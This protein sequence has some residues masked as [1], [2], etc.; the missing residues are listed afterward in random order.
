MKQKSLI[1]LIIVCSSIISCKKEI[2]SLSKN[3]KEEKTSIENVDTIKKKDITFDGKITQT[4]LELDLESRLEFKAK[5]LS[6]LNYIIKKI[7]IIETKRTRLI[8]GLER[9]YKSEKLKQQEIENLIFESHSAF[10]K[11]TLVINEDKN[12]YPRV[13]VEEHIFKDKKSAKEAFIF[14]NDLKKINSI[15]YNISKEPSSL[16]LE[17]NRLYFVISGGWYMM[18]I[19]KEVEKELKKKL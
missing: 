11:G 15:W 12:T 10:L 4:S 5:S 9:L 13:N 8:S 7:E 16:F 19:Y 14:L 17:E 2:D 1:Y 6:K 18:D 3:N